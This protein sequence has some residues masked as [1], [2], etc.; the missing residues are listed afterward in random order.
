[1]PVAVLDLLRE[2]MLTEQDGVFPAA[3]I[4]LTAED[5]DAVDAVRARVGSR[6]PAGR[7]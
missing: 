3:L 4:S 2:H 6:L 7:A 1:L 5:W